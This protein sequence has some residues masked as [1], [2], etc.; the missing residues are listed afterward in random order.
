[1]KTSPKQQLEALSMS[2]PYAFPS[3]KKH[4]HQT[5]SKNKIIVLHSNTF[6]LYNCPL[7]HSP[8]NLPTHS[9]PLR[10]SL[11]KAKASACPETRTAFLRTQL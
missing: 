7:L 1:M 2:S 10:A 8:N 9:L 6:K 3:L 4:P 11:A 5:I